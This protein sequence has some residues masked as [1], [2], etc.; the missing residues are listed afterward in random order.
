[1][2]GGLHTRGGRDV[3]FF[4]FAGGSDDEN[5]YGGARGRKIPFT[6]RPG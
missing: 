3:S 2:G 5:Q 4:F 1:M 6:F